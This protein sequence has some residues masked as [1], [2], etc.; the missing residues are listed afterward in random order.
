MEIMKVMGYKIGIQEK[1]IKQITLLNKQ[2]FSKMISLRNIE[3]VVL[4]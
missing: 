4:K 2:K 1:E 3:M